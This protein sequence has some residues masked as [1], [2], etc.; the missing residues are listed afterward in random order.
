M[1]P[2]RETLLVTGADDT[3]GLTG[4]SM[5]AMT[6][7]DKPRRISGVALR[8]DG[9]AWAPW[10]PAEDHPLYLDFKR[11]RTLSSG[12][13]YMEQKELLDKLRQ[14][15][16]GIDYVV[17][18]LLIGS[19]E[20]EELTSFALWGEGVSVAGLLP[21]ADMIAFAFLSGAEPLTVP[22]E[23]AV[24][25]VGDMMKPMAMYPERWRVLDFPSDRQ[26]RA[27]RG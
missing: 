22:W 21:R 27:M 14:R 2:D 25:V 6:R 26:L 9:D 1:I 8:L 10:L 13:D 4:M 17:P 3:C 19:V 24:E 20:V 18:Y 16:G 23:R 11:L 5:L 7:L 12:L 15:R